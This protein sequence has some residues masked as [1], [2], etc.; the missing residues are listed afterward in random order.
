MYGFFN[1]ILHIPF[2][3]G[4]A[5]RSLIG[6]GEPAVFRLMVG[7][8]TYTW[9]VAFLLVILLFVPLLLLWLVFRRLRVI[10]LIITVADVVVASEC[11]E[12][13]ISGWLDVLLW[14][15]FLIGQ[16]RYKGLMKLT[17]CLFKY[18]FLFTLFHILELRLS[19]DFVDS[20]FR[21]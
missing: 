19:P 21:I 5:I 9:F 2:F 12:G 8:A 4:P 6:V 7:V 11:C 20:H 13:I 3:R 16:V 1:F 10:S 14:H 15:A 18:A 17:E